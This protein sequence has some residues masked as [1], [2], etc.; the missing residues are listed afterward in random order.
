MVVRTHL[1]I[2]LYLHSL[3]FSFRHA[4]SRPDCRLASQPIKQP[5]K[6][7]HFAY[8]VSLSVILDHK[9]DETLLRAQGT[10]Y[11]GVILVLCVL[12][13]FGNV[14]GTTVAAMTSL[15]CKELGNE[16]LKGQTVSIFRV[17]HLNTAAQNSGVFSSEDPLTVTS[18]FLPSRS[19]DK[20]C[21]NGQHQTAT[22][23]P[24]KVLNVG[25][26]AA[27]QSLY[28]PVWGTPLV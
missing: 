19:S 2:R 7:I 10:T 22:R 4:F 21:R 16:S 26:G 8:L 9:N 23:A 17:F 27:R 28:S 3:P 11:S 6:V 20:C 14:R 5:D 12:A 15:R 24:W 1:S 18:T 25:T 13:A